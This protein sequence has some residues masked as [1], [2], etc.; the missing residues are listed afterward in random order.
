VK[1]GSRIWPEITKFFQKLSDAPLA[2]RAAAVSEPNLKM[3]SSMETRWR[4]LG[5]EKKFSQPD[6]CIS[7]Y[8]VPNYLFGDEVLIFGR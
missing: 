6:R 1:S 7:A 4:V 8:E 2:A 5:D 3:K